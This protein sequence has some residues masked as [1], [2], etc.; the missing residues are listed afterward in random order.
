LSDAA[1]SYFS[2]LSDAYVTFFLLTYLI[3]YLLFNYLLARYGAA[4]IRHR[5][6]ISEPDHDLDSARDH[7]DRLGHTPT[8]FLSVE[9]RHLCLVLVSR[10]L[11][12]SFSTVSLPFVLGRTDPL[13]KARNSVQC[14]L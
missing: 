5:F 3:A 14:L 11:C 10:N 6:I 13:L 2:N 9:G 4:R 8:P 1:S 12:R 7:L